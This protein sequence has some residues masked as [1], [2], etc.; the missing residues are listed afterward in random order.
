MNHHRN[1]FLGLCTLLA[2]A[3]LSLSAFAAEG[4]ALGALLD[5]DGAK[6]KNTFLPV[7]QAFR[8]SGEALGRDQVRVT[9][10][11]APGYYL[12]QKRLKFTPADGQQV[13]LGA[14]QLPQGEDHTDEFFGTQIVYREILQAQLA[15]A[16]A[17]SA[18]Q[19]LELTVGYQGCADAGLCYPP[20]TRTLKIDLAGGGS[21][22]AVAAGGAGDRYVS[23]QDRRA[24]VIRN[25][26]WLA[27]LSSFYVAG[28]L[29]AFTGCVL[30]TIPILSGLIVGAGN[31]TT[32]RAFLLSLTYVLGMSVTYTVAG[33]VTAASGLQVQALFQKTWIMVLFAAVF[34]LMASSM[35]GAFTLQMPSSIQTRLTHLSNRQRGGT[36]TGVAIM[37][38]LSALIVTACVAPA[39]IAALAVISQS[40]DVVRGASALFVMSLGMGT[41]LLVVGAS[42][43]RFLP[44]AGGWMDDIKRLAGCAMLG[45][46]AW[47]LA[48]LLTDT[49]A[50]LLYMVPALAGAWVLW[51]FAVRG[52]A[53][54]LA[55]AAGVACA[56]YAGLLA[57]GY[58][59]GAT[60]PLHPLVARDVQ[61][62]PQFAPVRTVAEL[63]ARVQ[64]ATA[65]GKGVLLDFY[66]DWCV[67]CKEMERYTFSDPAV[68]QLL[69]R[70]VL[71][72]ADVTA[73]NA[74]DQALL[75]RFAI[76]GPPTIAFYDAQGQELPR[77]RVVGFMK[78]PEFAAL[79]RQLG[80]EAPRLT[81]T[82]SIVSPTVQ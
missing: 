6:P 64:A 10:V 37:G 36:W 63:D 42:A 38:A 82:L 69:E 31:V 53:L 40:G 43:G 77:Y 55:R 60:D 51:R 79:L 16:S 30:P 76:V 44:R 2:G 71:L 73:N 12:Y 20:Q 28:L 14:P 29:V 11:I 15:V 13:T 50:L 3:W 56:L 21:A 26:S 18:A 1:R 5:T 19:P 17:G 32:L 48:R 80:G 59:R 52:N 33:A 58:A 34:V 24:D 39:M 66:A 7:D 27:M 75:K 49:Q 81:R 78:A 54:V 25:G 61:S 23:E 67:S 68:A 72:R 41:P 22:A 9:W 62:G 65:A 57:F 74:D 47:M 70:A 46:A 35:F 8:V 4:G 45:V